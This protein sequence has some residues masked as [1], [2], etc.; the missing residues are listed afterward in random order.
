M[1]SDYIENPR[2]LNALNKLKIKHDSACLIQSRVLCC[3]L[4]VKD[5]KAHNYDAVRI[6][7]LNL[8]YHIFLIDDG[9][10]VSYRFHK[11]E[12]VLSPT[13]QGFVQDTLKRCG[14]SD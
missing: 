1:Q 4:K 9:R 5:A 7:S 11:G 3:S 14:L 12:G 6:A 13:T 8:L 10:R 2:L